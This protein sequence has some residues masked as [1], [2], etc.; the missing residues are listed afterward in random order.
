LFDAP[1]A[2]RPSVTRPW[3]EPPREE[4]RERERTGSYREG[5]PFAYG[6]GFDP[7]YGRYNS[8]FYGFSG[9]YQGYPGGLGRSVWPGTGYPHSGSP[10]YSQPHGGVPFGNRLGLPFSIW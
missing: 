6:S 3:G 2:S 8:G 4:P 9:G 1:M 7:Y 5:S 10:L